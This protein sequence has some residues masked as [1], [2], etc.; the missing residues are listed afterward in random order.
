MNHLKTKIKE[1]STAIHKDVIAIRRYLHQHPEL[2]FQEVETA[3]YIATQ[4]QKMGIEHQHGVADTGV[5]GIIKGKNPD[6]KIIALRSDHDALPITEAN[7]VAYK[8]KNEG[9]MHACGHDVH[10]SSLLGTARI[11]DQLKEE[12]EGTIK[13]IFQPGEEKAPG[14]ASL[15]IKDGVLENPTPTLIF[16][17]HVHPP[18]EVGKVGMK[19]GIYMASTDE[20]YVSIKGKGGHGAL[21]QTCIDP[22]AI[23][24]QIITALQQVVSRYGDPTIPT[25]LTFGKINSIGGATNIIPEEVQLQGTFRTMNEPWRAEAKR[26]M[27]EI[28]EG[29]ATSMGASCDFNIVKGYPFLKNDEEMTLKAK[30]FAIEYLGKENVV[31]LPIRMTGEDFAFYSHR[32]PAVFYRLGIRNEAEGITAGLH[33]PTFN[34][35][36]N[37]LALSTGL[38]AW[39]AIK[40]LN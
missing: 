1:L 35:D 14:G 18:L 10:T 40:S 27:K 2:S 9:V 16:G 30:E 5:V 13:L 21:P 34:I 32:I 15:M 31:D 3:K 22:I 20:I 19:G 28:A 12:F 4:L 36:E 7:D 33:T 24:A 26:R 17:Q 8:S 23:S 29:I 6:K 37:A 39:M 38:M 25:V 11:L